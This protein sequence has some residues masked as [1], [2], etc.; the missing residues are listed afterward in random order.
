VAVSAVVSVDAGGVADA[1]DAL[2]SVVDSLVAVLVAEELVDADWVE[3]GSA[4]VELLVAV[5]CELSC[6]ALVVVADEDS[7]PLSVELL[8]VDVLLE[9]VVSGAVEDAVG[10]VV[11]VLGGAVS[12]CAGA[13]KAHVATATSAILPHT[14]NRTA[15]VSHLGV[16]KEIAF[17]YFAGPLFPVRGTPLSRRVVSAL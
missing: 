17:G 4:V 13:A 1:E 9:L 7:A 14:L 15:G 5:V 12:A 10:S 16:G 6:G 11:A 3:E 2:R 8:L